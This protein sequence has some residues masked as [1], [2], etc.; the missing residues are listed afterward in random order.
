MNK[1]VLDI[2]NQNKATQQFDHIRIGIASPEKILSWSY[3]SLI[4]I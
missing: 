1:E 3:L 2:F 4:H